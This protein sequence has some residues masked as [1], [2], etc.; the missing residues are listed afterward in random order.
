MSLGVGTEGPV[1]TGPE[2]KRVATIVTIAEMRH[3]HLLAMNITEDGSGFDRELV[4]GRLLSE[5]KDAK[6][7]SLP[8]SVS[9]RILLDAMSGLAAL[10]GARREGAPLDFVHGEFTPAN[11][12]VGRDGVG[13]LVPLV[14]AHWSPDA[15]P[16]AEVTAY[17][18]PEKL[19][20]DDFDQRAD[21]FSAGVLLWEAMMGRPL[22]Q[23][24]SIDEIVMQLVG[25]KVARPL[26]PGHQ[27]WAVELADVVMRALAVD[28]AHRWQHVGIMGADIETIAVGQM[29]KS[30]DVASLVTGRQ[31]SR[32]SLS[33]EVTMPLALQQS[34]SPYA[35]S[36][37]AGADTNRD[38]P[39][40]L[41]S[42]RIG[43]TVPVVATTT[44][45]GVFLP[46]MTTR[47]RWAIV[48]G[49]LSFSLLVLIVARYRS[50]E[51]TIESTSTATVLA[52][53]P[54]ATIESL[55][56]SAVPTEPPLTADVEPTPATVPTTSHASPAI[57][58]RIPASESK[59][60]RSSAKPSASAG[61][62][63]PK[64]DRF[65]LSRPVRPKPADD[66]FGL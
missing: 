47:R 5:L 17:S 30:S 11:I 44:S 39:F 9:L 27:A 49:A 24:L 15:P 45:P 29:A 26:V 23:G 4:G 7:G 33:D 32:D 55:P 50:L 36:V 62:T 63:K 19:L 46:S 3:P 61:R 51:R 58:P 35:S 59:G 20:G 18:A 40:G 8:L 34:L 12:V 2:D 57:S 42:P 28:P 1:A 22:F 13:R 60:P 43:S 10:H 37:P 56:P 16:Q 48:G 31:V 65:G 41:R 53:A 52:P 21:V 64:E 25:G 54:T 66:P 38:A 14:Q 6:G